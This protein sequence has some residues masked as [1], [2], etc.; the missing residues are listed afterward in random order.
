M[1]NTN[2]QTNNGGIPD[3]IINQLNEHTVGGFVLFYFNSETGEPEQV[4]TFDTPAHSLALQKHMSDWNEAVAQL[5]LDSSM[6]S[7]QKNITDSEDPES[8]ED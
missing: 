7:I 1:P 5:T 8:P 3:Q 2:K 6:Y 4:M